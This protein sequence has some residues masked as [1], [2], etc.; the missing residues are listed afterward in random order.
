MI[1]QRYRNEFLYQIGQIAI[2]F[3]KESQKVTINKLKLG[4]HA[5]RRMDTCR[6]GR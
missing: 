5:M 3:V 2:G 4:K 1:Y 6:S